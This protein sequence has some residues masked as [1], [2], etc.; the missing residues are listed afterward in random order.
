MKNDNV[1]GLFIKKYFYFTNTENENN[2]IL[3]KVAIVPEFRFI[4]RVIAPKNG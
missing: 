2:K 1:S 4:N 3:L